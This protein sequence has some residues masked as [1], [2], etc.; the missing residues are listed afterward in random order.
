MYVDTV[1]F[2]KSPL[3]TLTMTDMTTP[4]HIKQAVIK[5]VQHI[6]V[7]DWRVHLRKI[8]FVLTICFVTPKYQIQIVFHRSNKWLL[9][10]GNV[11]LFYIKSNIVRNIV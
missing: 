2:F 11:N 4:W 10:S 8:N 9:M 7:L 3:L 5:N 1:K 6:E